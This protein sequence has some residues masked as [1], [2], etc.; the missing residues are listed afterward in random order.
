MK[1]VVLIVSAIMSFVYF[2]SAQT[3]KIG[4][5]VWMVKNIDVS[6]FRNGDSIPEAKTAEEWLAYV[7]QGKPAWCYY[8]NV[9]AYGIKYGKLYNVHA[10]N[11]MRGLPPDGY[12]IPSTEEWKNLQQNCAGDGLLKAGLHL[13]SAKGWDGYF[14]F[15][16][17][18]VYSN[19]TNSSGFT[20]LPGGYRQKE[21]WKDYGFG[22]GPEYF[23]EFSSMGDEGRWWSST[24]S[25]N[26]KAANNVFVLKHNSHRL[27]LIG[28]K[29]YNGFSV[30]C[31][32]D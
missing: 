9:A 27:I 24:K 14:E 13:K 17:Q 19:G 1:K 32:K 3:V 5:Q 2:T 6:T 29:Y 21:E 22:E 25:G 15:G 20:G 10:V 31:I 4:N 16:G 18:M 23:P 30:R 26:A 12:H 7:V 8:N 28:G 11:D